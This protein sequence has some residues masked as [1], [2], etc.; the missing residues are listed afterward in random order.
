L[1]ALSCLKE[2][3][4][5]VI[6]SYRGILVQYSTPENLSNEWDANDLLRLYGILDQLNPGFHKV[7]QMNFIFEDLFFTEECFYTDFSVFN[8]DL[9]YIFHNRL[10]G[11]GQV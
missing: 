7:D 8:S 3:A 4:A 2:K 5:P 6:C 9:S 1:L 11:A 10:L